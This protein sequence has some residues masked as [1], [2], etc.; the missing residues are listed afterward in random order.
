MELLLSLIT[1]AVVLCIFSFDSRYR[2]DLGIAM[3]V[4]SV[5]LQTL[6]VQNQAQRN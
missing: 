4:A 5:L 2:Y 1:L 6:S 3:I